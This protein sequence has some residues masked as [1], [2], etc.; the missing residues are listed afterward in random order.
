MK[1]KI[2]DE[3]NQFHIINW[4]ILKT[5]NNKNENNV[6]K[7]TNRRTFVSTLN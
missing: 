4:L 1:E 6:G 3:E 2:N 7:N 5:N